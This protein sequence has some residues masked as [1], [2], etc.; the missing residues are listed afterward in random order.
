MCWTS[1]EH[2]STGC[3]HVRRLQIVY[4]GAMATSETTTVRIRRPDSERLRALAE[5]HQTTV[6]EVVHTAIDALERLEFARG[7]ND[8]FRRLRNDPDRWA[9]YQEERHAWDPLA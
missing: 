8:D 2:P 1:S 9:A 3:R 5:S 4:S 6:I 7:L